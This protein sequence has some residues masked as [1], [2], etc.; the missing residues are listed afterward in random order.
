MNYKEFEHLLDRIVAKEKEIGKTKAVE[1]T[2]NDDRLDNFKRLAK[3]LG[4]APEQILSVYLKKHLDAIM[5]YCRT[6]E[7]LSEDITGRILDARVYLSLLWGLVE[8]KDD[9]KDSI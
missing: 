3:E 6:G 2:Q 9:A 7:T 8:E 4:L 5:R 1:Y